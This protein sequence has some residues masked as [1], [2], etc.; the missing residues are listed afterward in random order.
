MSDSDSD[1]RVQTICLVLLAAVAVGFALWW[2]KPVLIPFVLALLLAIAVT[3]LVELLMR[4]LH[5]GRVFAV[6]IAMLLGAAVLV[7]AGT[8]VWLSVAQM[9][10]SAD[11]YAERAEGLLD[12]ALDAL[13]LAKLGLTRADALEG[14]GQLSEDAVRG[15]LTRTSSALTDVLSKGVLVLIFFCFLVF[16]GSG[17]TAKPGGDW[18]A[19]E[20]DVKRYTLAKLLLSAATGALVGLILWLLGIPLAGVFGMLAF[21]LNFIPSVGSIIAVLLPLPVVLLTPGIS[22]GQA[23][24]AIALPGAVEFAIGNVIEPRLMGKR[25]GL[26]PIAVMMALIFWGMLWGI[27]GM[28]L[29]VP[30]TVL[31]RRIMLK[32]DVTRPVAELLAGHGPG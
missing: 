20:A 5:V 15:L 21:L 32:S 16:G 12:G 25:L 6:L 23:V 27:V 2:L 8:V 14:L 19:V 11:T 18:A 28:F 1:R 26:H 22:A 9:A 10:E 3:P 31:A 13:P 30:M 17:R 24:L 29:A 4:K 7:L